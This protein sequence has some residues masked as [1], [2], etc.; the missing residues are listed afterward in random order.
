MTRSP[1]L[2]KLPG[3]IPVWKMATPVPMLVDGDPRSFLARSTS[4]LKPTLPKHVHY[5]M[6]ARGKGSGCA[7]RDRWA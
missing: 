2:S 4:S 5:S 1:L 6:Y 3:S 7:W